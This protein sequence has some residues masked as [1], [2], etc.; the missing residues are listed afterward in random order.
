[1]SLSANDLPW[2][3]AVAVGGW[4]NRAFQ[5]EIDLVGADRAPVARKIY[6]VG[7]VKWLDRAFDD[8]DLAAMQRDAIAVPG[9]EPGQTRL[10]AVSRAG[11]RSNVSRQLALCWSARDVV[12]AFSSD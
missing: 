5:P 6:Y 1:L 11:A 4:W 10:A 12:A 8:H 2:P 7:S 9:F 3:D